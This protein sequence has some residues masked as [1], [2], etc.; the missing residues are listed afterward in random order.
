MAG[1]ECYTIH[2]RR[3]VI[4]LLDNAIRPKFGSICDEITMEDVKRVLSKANTKGGGMC[5]SPEW[6]YLMG[7]SATEIPD[8]EDLST[9]PE[10]L[11]YAMGRGQGVVEYRDI[12]RFF[13]GNRPADYKEDF[14]IEHSP[15]TRGFINVGAIQ[16]PG[17]ASAPAKAKMVEEILS[18]AARDE[19]RA[20]EKKGNWQPIRKAKHEFRRLSHEEQDKLIAEDPS[21]GRIICRCEKIT[22]GEILEVMRSP[23]IPASVDA[24]KR[25]ARAGMGRCQG[26]FCQPRVLELLARELGR[27]PTEITLKGEGSN[28]LLRPNRT[29]RGEVESA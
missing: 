3:G 4:A 9:T 15:V 12:I 13:S 8:K 1:D 28:I 24:I 6:H 27:D 20:L 22:E 21:F 14:V 25:R 10:D 7:P 29:K 23:I 26:G 11:A 16:S 5:R 2:P 19:G 18:D 17:L